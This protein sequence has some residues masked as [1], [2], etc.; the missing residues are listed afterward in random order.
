MRKEVKQ[1]YANMNLP[2]EKLVSVGIR[3]GYSSGAIKQAAEELYDEMHAPA[4]YGYIE[5]IRIAW[6]VYDRAKLVE[7]VRAENYNELIQKLIEGI[8]EIKAELTK[9]KVPW[10]EKVLR[11]FNGN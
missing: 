1:Y 8:G 9:K 10:H 7:T 2:V 11:W 5:P 6:M 4:V 3:K